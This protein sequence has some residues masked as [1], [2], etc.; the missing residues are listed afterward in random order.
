MYIILKG[1][2]GKTCTSYLDDMLIFARTK[3]EREDRIEK[4]GFTI[5][6]EKSVIDKKR[7]YVF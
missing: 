3:E 2:I 7:G 1:F 4:Y 6:Y 5:N